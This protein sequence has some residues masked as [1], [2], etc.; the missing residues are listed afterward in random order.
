MMTTP[1]TPPL[2][3]KKSGC[4]CS[5]FTFGCLFGMLLI[6]ALPIAS[7][8][9]G[10]KYRNKVTDAFVEYGYHPVVRPQLVRL[11]KGMSDDDR[12]MLLDRIDADVAA[13][14]KL[15]EVERGKVLKKFRE[16]VQGLLQPQK[17]N[18]QAA[19]E[20]EALLRD[21]SDPSNVPATQIEEKD[22]QQ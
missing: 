6:L 14:M 12:K 18:T 9:Y 7:G 10:Y 13:Y 4:G 2:A 17:D 5:A 22:L 21:M 3:P 19:Q 20:I 8:Y 1:L 11:F 16:F 15:P